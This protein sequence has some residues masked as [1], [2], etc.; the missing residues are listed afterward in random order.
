MDIHRC[1]FVPYPPAAINAL[2]FSHPSP[3]SRKERASP[4]LKLAIGRDNGSIEIWK[5]Q[6]GDWF[7]ETTLWGGKGRT[8]DALTWT[9][10]E[11]LRLFSIGH[12]SVVTEWDL[13]EGVPLRQT[14]TS[15][16]LWCLAAQPGLERQDLAL[17][18]VDGS[19]I[20]LST[21]DDNLTYSRTLARST[22]KKAQV[23][24]ITFK[25]RQTIVTGCADSRIRIY[26]ARNGSL[27]RTMSLGAGPGK[28]ILVWSVKCLPDGNIVSGDA[29]GE[30]RFWDGKT[31]TLMQR[32]RSH[33]ADVF[34]VEVSPDG[35]T[36]FSGSMDRRT[37]IYKKVGRRWAEISHR[38]FHSHDVKAMV[39]FDSKTLSVLVSGG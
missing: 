7:E 12:S 27:L 33:V 14:G 31:Y 20:I 37:V 34:E 28:D 5:P 21:A 19:V 16:E 25:D 18:C 9:C 2:A 38:R 3:K 15:N 23:L 17:G 30:V 39:I 8:I 22:S 4:D 36:I 32:L 10:S 13:I 35:G 26:D 1:R 29:T 24:S 6:D 11:K